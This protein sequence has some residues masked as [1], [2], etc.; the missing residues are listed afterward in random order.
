MIANEFVVDFNE[1]PHQF[2]ERIRR[3]YA[4][5]QRYVDQWSS[6]TTVLVAKFFSFLLGPSLLIFFA[7][8]FRI[9]FAVS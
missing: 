5:T 9:S 2:D 6:H 1:L 8:I 7:D 4:P 3:S